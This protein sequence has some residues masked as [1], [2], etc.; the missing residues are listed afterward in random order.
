MSTEALLF[1]VETQGAATFNR[2]LRQLE[3]GY[4]QL[5]ESAATA[6]QRSRAGS[7]AAKRDLDGM[8]RSMARGTG[9]ARKLGS[10]LAKGGAIAGAT[11]A[12]V[13]FLGV[14]LFEFALAGDEAIRVTNAFVGNLGALQAAS[15]DTVDD[16]SLM[17]LDQ[18][19]RRMVE[20]TG[21]A[22]ELED[23]LTVATDRFAAGLGESV[24]ANAT[25]ILKGEMEQMKQIGVVIDMTD[26]RL[27][28]LDETR[29]KAMATQ[30]AAAEASAIEARGIDESGLAAAQ[31]QT[32][33]DNLIS[34][35]QAL[36]AEFITS[37]GIVDIVSEAVQGLTGW[38]AENKDMILDIG[39]RALGIMTRGF[40][41]LGP[42]LQWVADVAL[43]L[44]DG[45]TTVIKTAQDAID[46]L[47]PFSFL[48]DTTGEVALEAASGQ[49]ELAKNVAEAGAAAET[50]A[51]Q[52][53][54]L[55]R[56]Q[57][58]L[59]A[60]QKDGLS[61][62]DLLLDFEKL[63]AELGDVELAL[64]Q[65][66]NLGQTSVILGAA[67]GKRD[68][69]QARSRQLGE[70]ADKA[71]EVSQIDNGS[72]IAASEKLGAE[73]RSAGLSAGLT[74]DQLRLME[75]E[76]LEAADKWDGVTLK[77][78]DN[79]EA[80]TEATKATTAA[81]REFKEELDATAIAQ[82]G[83]LA[84]AAAGGR[85]VE[86]EAVGRRLAT[87]FR[88]G[89]DGKANEIAFEAKLDALRPG[90][91]PID[92]R[93]EV[94]RPPEIGQTAAEL[95]EFASVAARA[96]SEYEKLRGSFT[97]ERAN[98]LAE[99]LLT[100]ATAFEAAAQ[101]LSESSTRIG[102]AFEAYEDG[103][104]AAVEVGSIVTESVLQAGQAA[105]NAVVKNKKQQ[106]LINALFEGAMA[107]AAAAR[108]DFVAAAAHGLAAVKFGAIAGNGAGTQ[109]SSGAA[110]GGPSRRE[111]AQ[112]RI[113]PQ[114]F[115]A[116][117]R[118]DG[119]GERAVREERHYH[120]HAL[121][122]RSAFET[123]TDM[124]NKG[125]KRRTGRYIDARLVGGAQAG[126]L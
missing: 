92:Q 34:E 19:N 115:R 47:N 126:G 11:A 3:S 39:G 22:V 108:L 103:S 78:M 4:Y 95:D 44:A 91:A 24:S 20:A 123:L 112:A 85:G 26:E 16:T 88:Q 69:L 29:K 96:N 98:A 74:A 46:W 51:K 30:I 109:A 125:A 65:V 111:P 6:S 21:I 124:L 31:A 110:A 2:Q 28:G 116:T 97:G 70:L 87:S 122:H 63:A 48:M 121:D 50:S 40:E 107:V 52:V 41:T 101:S 10:A 73:L 106:A 27:Q 79:F 114:T 71:R 9:S 33:V 118:A 36:A 54:S 17:K 13:G 1:G 77:I 57:S 18:L 8:N 80:T 58:A 104:M 100:V 67:G 83:F 53:Q 59:D 94:A 84:G 75:L 45:I 93:G 61:T 86:M 14:Q 7:A 68:A 42:I 62:D 60:L 64:T 55:I 90:G 102:E 119:F 81:T 66:E 35:V 120:I 105:T 37:T 38:F 5:G 15:R 89:F 43:I 117:D 12:A 113:E 32:S 25:A 49:R 76:A 72:I 82:S 23:V 56:A 99:G